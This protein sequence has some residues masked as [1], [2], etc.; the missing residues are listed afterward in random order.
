MLRKW[1]IQK[2]FKKYDGPKPELFGRYIDDCLGDTSCTK[3]ELEELFS[4]SI[5]FIRL[6]SLLGK[7]RIQQLLFWTSKSQSKRISW[8]P[9]S[10]TNLLTHTVIFPIHLHSQFML[11]TRFRT[12]R[13]C[14]LCSDNLDFQFICSEMSTFFS[15]RTWLSRSRN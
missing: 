11:K 8:P 6:L 2:I 1:R 13:L 15:E 5:L 7:F 12:L 3:D 10:T 14:R 9:A 4:S